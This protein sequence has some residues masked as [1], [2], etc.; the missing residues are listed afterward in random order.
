MFQS[1]IKDGV[2]SKYEKPLWKTYQ[3]IYFTMLTFVLIVKYYES[4][5]FFGSSF[6]IPYYIYQ[7]VYFI[8]NMVLPFLVVIN[9]GLI[10]LSLF[11]LSTGHFVWKKEEI[12]AGLVILVIFLIPYFLFDYAQPFWFA[13]FIFCAHNIDYKKL[14][15]VYVLAS[16]TLFLIIFVSSC[17]GILEDTLFYRSN[18]IVRHG[19]GFIYT[20]WPPTHLFFLTACWAWLREEHIS[21]YEIGLVGVFAVFSYVFC[22]A[23]TSVI[24]ISLIFAFLLWAKIR[25]QKSQNH[26][27]LMTKPLQIG[28]ILSYPIIALV[29][30]IVSVFY[31]DDNPVL[32]LIN[33][34]ISGRLVLGQTGFNRFDILPFGQLIEMN[35]EPPKEYF[36]LDCSYINIL[37]RY[38]LL[39]FLGVMFICLYMCFRQCEKKRFIRLG[40]LAIVAIKISME[41]HIMEI[42]HTPIL[43]YLL[44]F[45]PDDGE[46]FNLRAAFPKRKQHK[47]N[48]TTCK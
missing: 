44:A 12:I 7:T 13:I 4:S 22:H 31:S 17:T 8:S 26:K 43:L 30:T 42:D 36:F 2:F 39:V 28:C 11:K 19:F 20:T 18:G 41:Y 10:V 5:M 38:G 32:N 40:L 34:L 25:S 27:Y 21:Y 14:V 6:K 46:G 15:K 16:I 45:D 29:M 33:R 47:Q 9:I 35:T 1:I 24:S 23:R 37:L 48:K 3:Y